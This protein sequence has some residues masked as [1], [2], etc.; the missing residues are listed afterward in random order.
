[1]KQ[2][3]GFFDQDKPQHVCKLLK[4]IYGLKQTPRAWYHEL[5]SFF[6][7]YGFKNSVVDNSLV[8]NS[9]FILQMQSHIL[10]L[11]I[12]VDDIIVTGNNETL[13]NKFV[14]TLARRFTIKDLEDLSYFLE[15]EV[16][17]NQMEYYHHNTNTSKTY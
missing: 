16:T 6:I 13:T 3:Q 10:Y 12:Y 7:T 11:L 2:P 4:A 1:M 14:D 8:D 15:I 5:R 9:L 17:H